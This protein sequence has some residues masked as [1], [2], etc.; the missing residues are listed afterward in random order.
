[1][2]LTGAPTTR[3]HIPSALE[4]NLRKAFVDVDMDLPRFY[5]KLYNIE[6]TGIAKERE[7]VYGGI[8]SY[9]AKD[10]GGAP[11][12][13][14]G[15]EAWAKLYEVLTFALGL[16]VTYEAMQDDRHGIIRKMTAAGGNLAEVANYTVEQQV[17]NLFNT[18]LTSGEVYSKD[19]T[20][21]PLVSL[22]HPL[23]DGSTWTNRPT[24]PMDLSIEALEFAVG[25]WAINQK[26]QR[27]QLTMRPPEDLIV[28]AN[29]WM[30]A[31]RLQGTTKLPTSANNDINPVG[32]ILKRVIFNPLLT[33]DGRWGLHADKR[34]TGL[35]FYWRERPNV[36]KWPDG[37]NGNTRLVG[38]FRKIHGATHTMNV[39]WSPAS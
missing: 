27:G 21:Y 18:L 34:F 37:D 5:D 3:D 13:D 24:S 35:R 39:W 25:H 2:A 20:T 33:N 10:E 29:D 12:Y 9:V 22:T 26:N 17:M 19:G 15:Q 7:A 16:Q 31:K 14:S 8:G 36:K 6:N 4:A 1:M 38:F 23:L 11:T 28:A 30:L 32:D